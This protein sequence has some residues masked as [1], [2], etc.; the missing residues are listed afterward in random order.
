MNRLPRNSILVGDATD[1]LRTCRNP[2]RRLI[3]SPPYYMLRNY[4]VENQIGLEPSVDGWVDNLRSVCREVARVLKPD[5]WPLAQSGRFV[6]RNE[7]TALP[8]R[9]CCA[10]RNDCCWR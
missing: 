6:L 1:K 2:D 4:F 3:T 10:R 9:G 8:R 7:A 5:R